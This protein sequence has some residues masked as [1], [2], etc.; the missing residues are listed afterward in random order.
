M[1][2]WAEPGETMFPGLRVFER[3]FS[4]MW[5]RPDRSHRAE[6][7]LILTDRRI[8]VLDEAHMRKTSIPLN[9]VETAS[10]VSVPAES[11][12]GSTTEA[13]VEV[14]VR[15][16][17]QPK[18]LRWTAGRRDAEVFAQMVRERRKR[19]ER[20]NGASRHRPQ[21]ARTTP[22][23]PPRPKTASDVRPSAETAAPDVRPPAETA[24]PDVRP[25]VETAAPDVRPPAETASAGP[26]PAKTGFTVPVFDVDDAKRAPATPLPEGLKFGDSVIPW[27]DFERIT[28]GESGTMTFTVR[29]GTPSSGLVP[30]WVIRVPELGDAEATWREFITRQRRNGGAPVSRSAS[31]A[32]PPERETTL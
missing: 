31:T 13:T 21:P 9:E 24:A 11:N 23:V 15:N 29:L 18:A 10:V 28:V 30:G 3:D 19:V 16:G 12:G 17:S 25:P 1:K 20:R 27:S 2:A 14:L 22:D 5:D 6:R 8:L 7:T 26:P 32:E 4:S